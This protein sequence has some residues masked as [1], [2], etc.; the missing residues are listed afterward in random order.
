MGNSSLCEG[1]QRKSIK[2]ACP[3]AGQQKEVTLSKQTSHV[4]MDVTH[5]AVQFTYFR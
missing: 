4:C 3:E 5:Y 1:G 2:T